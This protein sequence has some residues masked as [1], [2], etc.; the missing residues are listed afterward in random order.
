MWVGAP[1]WLGGSKVWDPSPPLIV[2][3]WVGGS[4]VQGAPF[5]VSVGTPLCWCYGVE[6]DDVVKEWATVKF[7]KN[8]DNVSAL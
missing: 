3:A 1:A 4:A 5:N 6:V 2:M 7:H 8:T